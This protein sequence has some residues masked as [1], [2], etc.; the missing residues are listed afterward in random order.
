MVVLAHL[1]AALLVEDARDADGAVVVGGLLF[2]DVEALRELQLGVP[3]SESLVGREVKAAIVV[4][5]AD[6]QGLGEADPAR[7]EG[8]MEAAIVMNMVLV[9]IIL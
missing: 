2:W 9:L 4:V 8:H 3:D 5:G 6:G 7:G 1:A